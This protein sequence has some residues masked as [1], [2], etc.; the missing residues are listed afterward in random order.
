MNNKRKR[1]FG[2]TP[3]GCDN[4]ESITF[5]TLRAGV[6]PWMRKVGNV[7]ES[8][9]PNESVWFPRATQGNVYISCE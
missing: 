9:L 5:D 3:S 4:S 2:L 7:V 6:F 8:I 1:P